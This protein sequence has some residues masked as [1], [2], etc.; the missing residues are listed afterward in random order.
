MKGADVHAIY[1]L[2]LYLRS[3][4]DAFDLVMT[5]LHNKGSEYILNM[6]SLLE[7]TLRSRGFKL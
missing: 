4:E 6:N 3:R 7:R 5:E 1:L 2:S